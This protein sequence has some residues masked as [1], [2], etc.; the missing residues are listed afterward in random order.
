MKKYKIIKK[1]RLC[2]WI[3]LKT[4][5]DLGKSPLCDQ[6]VKKKYKQIFFPL[7]LLLCSDCGFSQINCVVDKNYIYKNYIYETKSSITLDRH[8]SKYADVVSKKTNLQKNDLVLDIGSND[9]MLLKKFKKKSYK[10]LGVEPA[11]AIAK[12]ANK[13]RLK[14][15]NAFFDKKIVNKI[16][17]SYKKPKIITMNNLFANVDNLNDFSNNLCDLVHENGTIVIETSY[18]GY[19][20][21]NKIF[22]WIYH[23]HL[24]YFSIN[25]LKSFFEKKSFKLYDLDIS[26]S[27]G[28][29]IRYYF[30]NKTNN[31][32]ITKLAKDLI[33]YEKK[34]KMNSLNAFKKFKNKIDIQKKRV[35]SLLNKL[36]G[37]SIAGYGASATTTTLLSYFG[38]FKFFKYLIDDNPGKIGLYSPG[39]HIPV[40]SSKILKNNSPKVIVIL[41][42]RYKDIIL[43]NLK[44]LKK[45]YKIKKLLVIVPL[46][47]IKLYNL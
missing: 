17:S 3:N 28:G 43:K 44:M 36:K 33:N 26:N 16:I 20:F 29:S 24:S 13:N 15:I 6:Y 40:F 45:K 2:L 31:F 25:P 38:I 7:K 11:H 14:T 32:P 1:C 39:Y 8:F 34:N 23:E 10:V 46:P 35:N 5:F 18:M 47:I 41:A 27:K 42:W 37:N 22:D 9:G 4:S 12:I 21:K 30:T 19:I